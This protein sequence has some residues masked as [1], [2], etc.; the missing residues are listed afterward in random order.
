MADDEQQRAAQLVLAAQ[1]GDTLALHDLLDL[2]VPFVGRICG[3]IALD[4]GP[5]A[6]Q[7]TL[8]VVMRALRGLHEPGAVLGWV[9]TIAVREALRHARRDTRTYPTDT[10]TLSRLPARD[11]PQLHTDVR[12]VMARLS[13]D[14]RAVLLLRDLHGYDEASAADLLHLPV[15]TV[16]SRLY[17]ARA[18]FRKEWTQ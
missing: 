17:R 11:D 2:L 13:P 5:D 15:G 1:H 12:A 9:R 18:H 7:D 4:S 8:I 10:E 14:H 3:A 16:K 6:A